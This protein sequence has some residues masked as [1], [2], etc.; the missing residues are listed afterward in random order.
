MRKRAVPVR[1]SSAEESTITGNSG[2]CASELGDRREPVQS[3]Q[4]DVEDDSVEIGVLRDERKRLPCVPGFLPDR[5][6]G[7]SCRKQ[8]REP[9]PDDRMIVD[10]QNLHGR[11]LS[12]GAPA[13]I[14]CVRTI[15]NRRR[16]S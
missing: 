11:R 2:A 12:D 6:S 5:V 3:G 1:A 16:R 9:V 13:A 10:D 4:N 14:K 15:R 7:P 8:G